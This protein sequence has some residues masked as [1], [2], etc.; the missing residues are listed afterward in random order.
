MSIVGAWTRVLQK[1]SNG[2]S[3]REREAMV[4]NQSLLSVHHT[5]IG[6]NLEYMYG[7]RGAGR[8]T[9]H[10]S[11]QEGCRHSRCRLL[12]QGAGKV[13]SACSSTRNELHRTMLYHNILNVWFCMPVCNTYIHD[14]LKSSSCFLLLLETTIM[15]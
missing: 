13:F 3:E 8:E 2:Q 15:I 4:A 11:V 5:F 7:Q 10:K 1:E 9:D 14:V 12:P 6:C